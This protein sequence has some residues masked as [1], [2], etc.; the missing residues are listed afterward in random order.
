MNRK[1]IALISA[2]LFSSCLVKAQAPAAPPPSAPAPIQVT[3][4]TVVTTTSQVAPTTLPSSAAM[5][6]P[7]T[8]TA[9]GAS[10]VS[11]PSPTPTPGL[12][13]HLFAVIK[14]TA[15]KITI[16]L[17]HVRAP[18]TV[19]NFT[20]L[21]EGKKEFQ[22]INTGLTEKRPFY[23]GLKIHRVVPNFLIQMGCPIGDSRG[24]PGYKIADEIVP[25]LR[26]DRPGMVAMANE[27][28]PASAGSQFFITV[29][30]APFLD[31]KNSIFG[32][33]VKG[34]DVVE[35]ISNVKTKP[36]TEVPKEP[37]TITNI[38]IIRKY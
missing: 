28:T 12:V 18:S 11:Q 37:I 4:T 27:G 35:K 24:G 38:K 29:K 5:P 23:D 17:F 30:E 10:S 22:A 8:T 7:P 26:F 32:E 13:R 3:A 33:V 15:G 21:A 34:M 14:T 25:D 20:D 9:E 19:E 36:G 1:P 2:I 16:R 6:P 31:G